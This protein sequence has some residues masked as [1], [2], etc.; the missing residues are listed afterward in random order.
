M[1]SLSSIKEALN[2]K[3]QVDYHKAIE[4]TLAQIQATVIEKEVG[5]FTWNSDIDIFF[6]KRN[7]STLIIQS[8][9][10]FEICEST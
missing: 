2:F 8:G 3:S 6:Y 1:L 5:P 10:L 4:D 7:V 9:Q